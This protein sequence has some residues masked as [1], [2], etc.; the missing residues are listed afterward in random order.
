MT[1]RRWLLALAA[2]LPGLCVLAQAPAE[3][4]SYSGSYEMKSP[5]EAR[6]EV[7]LQVLVKDANGIGAA[8]FSEFTD[9]FK[10]LSSFSGSITSGGKVVKKLRKQD[11]MGSNPIVVH[12][13]ET[14]KESR[15]CHK[16]PCVKWFT[17][18]TDKQFPAKINFPT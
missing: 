13:L 14:N 15:F 17:G 1:K 2:F 3:V 6:Y 5:T 16:K 4:L 7:H 10:T 9:E 8:T 18:K 11:V 12:K